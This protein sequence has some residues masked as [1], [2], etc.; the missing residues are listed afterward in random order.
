V[1]FDY[2]ALTGVALA[3][4]IAIRISVALV[5][6]REP[7]TAAAYAILGFALIAVFLVPGGGW[8]DAY[9]F[10]RILAPLLVLIAI[11][12]VASRTPSQIWLGIAPTLLVDSR[13]ALNLGKQALGVLHGLLHWA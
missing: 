4:V 3:V 9:A 12:S 2:L 7:A 8:D 13:I 10:G 11:Y 5:A 6:G 1:A